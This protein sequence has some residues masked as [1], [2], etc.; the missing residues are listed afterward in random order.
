MAFRSQA[1][2]VCRTIKLLL[3]AT[4]V[5]PSIP[6]TNKL[7]NSF[8]QDFL[9]HS[10]SYVQYPTFPAQPC[11]HPLCFTEKRPLPSPCSRG[12]TSSIQ[13]TKETNANSP[14]KRPRANPTACEDN[15]LRVHKTKAG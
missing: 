9:R 3:S 11:R 14:H 5:P 8:K 12:I 1:L 2:L 4:H 15:K 7:A 13:I 10:S 6:R